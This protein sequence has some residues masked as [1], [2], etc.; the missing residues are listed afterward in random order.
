MLQYANRL[1]PTRGELASDG[2]SSSSAEQ[3][4]N[5]PLAPAMYTSRHV[6]V[7]VCVCVFFASFGFVMS[8]WLLLEECPCICAYSII[9]AESATFGTLG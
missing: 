7:C 5:I 8:A 1:A 6:C 9:Q 2:K 4:H 3:V